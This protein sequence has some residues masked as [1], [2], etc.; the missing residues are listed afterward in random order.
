MRGNQAYSSS[1]VFNPLKSTPALLM[2]LSTPPGSSWFVASAAARML[3]GLVTSKSRSTR[4]PSWCCAFNSCRPEELAV[5]RAVAMTV[6]SLSLSY[7]FFV[8]AIEPSYLQHHM[9]GGI[10]RAELTS[11]ATKASPSPRL[12]PV[13]RY[14]GITVELYDLSIVEL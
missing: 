13:I 9:N 4:R 14:E 6:F 8:S 10:V 2:R 12:A 5:F 7:E 1:N 11:S 3:S